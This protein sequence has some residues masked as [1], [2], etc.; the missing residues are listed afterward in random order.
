MLAE[1]P[2]RIT[3]ITGITAKEWVVRHLENELAS[4][5]PKRV[6]KA[7]IALEANERFGIGNW[8]FHRGKP[9]NLVKKAAK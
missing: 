2:K 4:G 5:D 9:F 1:G 6:K 8:I 7:E 3:G